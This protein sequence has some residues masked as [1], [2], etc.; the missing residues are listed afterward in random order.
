MENNQF[1]RQAFSRFIMLTFLDGLQEVSGD[2]IFKGGNLLWHYV[3]T[4]RETIDLDL[5][6]L[7]LNS[8][9]EVRKCI[10]SSFKFH[11]EIDFKI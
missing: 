3:K 6:T 10:E 7:S 1:G 4:P 11:E 2:F 8:H 5:A 9:Q